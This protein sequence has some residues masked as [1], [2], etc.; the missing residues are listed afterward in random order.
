MAG[1]YTDLARRMEEG[2]LLKAVIG[3]Y[4]VYKKTW[5]KENIES[6]YVLQKSAKDIGKTTD[7]ITRL[8]ELHR[9]VGKNADVKGTYSKS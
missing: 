8:Q 7:A 5:L 6:E 1:T 9:R 4:I 3:D 2:G